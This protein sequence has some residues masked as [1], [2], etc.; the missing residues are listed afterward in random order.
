MY[1][2][3]ITE[4]H[5]DFVA[6][7][8]SAQEITSG[9][10]TRIRTFN[11]ELGAFLSVF[12]TQAMAQAEVLDAKRKRKEPVGKL[13]GVPIA[14]KDLIQ[15]K[16][17]VTTCASRILKKH[18]ALYD[19]TL[20]RLMR[21]ADAIFLGKTN[22]DEFAMGSTTETSAY[23]KTKNP[24][25]L[26]CNPGGSSGG[27]SAAVAARLAPAA[28]GTDTGG[29]I[30]QPAAFTGIVGFKPT[31]GRVSRYGVV[32]FASSLDTIGPMAGSVEEI[33]Y[34]MEV[35]GQH[36]P[37]DAT[38]QKKPKE[39]FLSELSP[40]IR[41]KKVGVPW[42]FFENLEPELKKNFDLGVQ[43]LKDLGVDVT[44]IDLPLCR[45]AIPIYY[46]IATAEASTNLA[47]FDGIQYSHRAK[48][49]KTLEEIYDLSRKEGFGAEVKKR[50]MIGTYVLSSG[51]QDAYYN[52]A[53]RIRTLII[54]DFQKAF[55]TVD[56]IAMPTTPHTA[57]PFN[58]IPDDAQ[59]HLQDIYT[60]SA[61]LAGLPAISIPSGI[62]SNNK[63]IGF[64][65]LGPPLEDARV[66]RFAAHLE[67]AF[68]FQH[69]VAPDYAKE[70][71]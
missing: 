39:P 64:Q 42:A 47:R 34:L 17:E 21:E 33:A 71:S 62:H 50:I 58:W 11:P 69:V 22:L 54:R 7:R 37:H 35:I 23:C 14:I 52:R 30:R 40:S 18:R 67:K 51:F 32:A 25:D 6:G 44:S 43:H 20:I 68:A 70:P 66:L 41:G 24:W 46:V 2:K 15:I 57:F 9:Y 53:R 13:A 19:A 3:K 56:I 12:E 4:L 49:A 28:I 63:P 65:L 60:V 27:S 29:S 1:R 38:S 59:M 55:Q 31:Y 8:L 36:C 26:T 61:N 48:S 45:Y 10:L 16:G 5:K